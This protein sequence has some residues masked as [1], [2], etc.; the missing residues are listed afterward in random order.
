MYNIDVMEEIA[1]NIAVG[2]NAVSKKVT[3]SDGKTTRYCSPKD[4]KTMVYMKK[5]IGN[6]CEKG[7]VFR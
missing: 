7:G 5:S 6:H 3:F 2:A 1:D 4:L